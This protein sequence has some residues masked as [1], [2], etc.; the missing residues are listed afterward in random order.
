MEIRAWLRRYKELMEEIDRET[1]EA[2]YWEDM[3]IGLSPTRLSFAPKSTRRQTMSDYVSNFL[4]LARHCAELGEQARQAKNEIITAI[5]SLED[6]R[7]RRVLKMIYI[8]Q[9]NYGEIAGRLHYSKRHIKRLHS[10]GV[11]ILSRYVTVE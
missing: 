10:K 5:D 3:A 4:D 2:H 7:H 8:D 1:K 11:E 9:L 6:V